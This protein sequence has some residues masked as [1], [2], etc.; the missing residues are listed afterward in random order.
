MTY[1]QDTSPYEEEIVD[2][3]VLQVD[4]LG[5][6]NLHELLQPTVL[7]EDLHSIAELKMILQ[8]KFPLRES[9]HRNTL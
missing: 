3:T 8:L 9:P 5:N 2:S 1:S 4:K 6:N 7:K